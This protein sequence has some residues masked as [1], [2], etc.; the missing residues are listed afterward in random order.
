MTKRLTRKEV[1]VEE[2]WRLEDLF[3]TMEDWE[4]ALIAMDSEIAQV[5]RYRGLLREESSMLLECLEAAENLVRKSYHVDLYAGLLLASDGTN[6]ANQAIAGRAAAAKARVEAGLSFIEPEILGLPDGTVEQY[7]AA[8]PRLEPFR[9][10]LE[11]IISNKPYVLSPETEEVL[12]SLGEITKAPYMLYNRTKSSDMRFEPVTDSSGHEVPVSFATYEVMLEKSPDTALR[13]NAFLSFTKGISAYQNVLGGT[14]GTEIR[15]NVVLAKA[16]G[17]ESATHMFLHGQESSL[18]AYTN[19]LDIIQEEIA[20]HMRRYVELR[21]T[22]LGL[23][24]IMYCDIEAPL[25]PGFDPELTF[26]EAGRKI[27]EAAGVMGKEYTD[28]IRAALSDRWIDR[29]DNIG[30]STGAF[31]AG[32]YDAHP[33]ILTTWSN[34]ARSMFTLAHELGHAVAD[35][36]TTRNQRFANIRMSMFIVEG[37]ST[38]NEMLLARHVLAESKDVRTRRWV[39]MQALS[40]YYHDYVRHML[41]AELLRRIYALAEAG[42]PVTA[43]VLSATQGEILSE[44][45][46]GLVEVDEG[47][48]L[49]WMRQPHYYMGLYPYTY[50]AGLTCSTLMA[51]A[52]D[53]EGQPAVD[54]W[55]EVLKAG[56]SMKPLEL[57]HRAGIDLEDPATIMKAVDYVG[58]L[59]DEV[60]KSF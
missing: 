8:E 17:F 60:E 55:L 6:P 14:F 26:E 15:K 43:S 12:A 22:A 5:T 48:S 28:I 46:D 30:K 31:C 54:R 35:V 18:T 52:I 47:A 42:T 59:V 24:K 25:D 57:M 20:P 38:F 16:R 51:R 13:H 49:T 34:Y 44:F 50:S 27:I 23:D 39:I 7:L 21:K 2:T 19:L 56:G 1:P 3:P 10:N 58:R 45:W 11:K 4:A 41:E 32:S 29:V 53:E 37:P 9:R 36:F 33:Y 40:T